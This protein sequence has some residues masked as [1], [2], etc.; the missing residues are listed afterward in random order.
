MKEART[1]KDSFADG[2]T[3][4]FRKEGL[5]IQVIFTKKVLIIGAEKEERYEKI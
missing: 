5:K 3:A 2:K 1:R 4:K